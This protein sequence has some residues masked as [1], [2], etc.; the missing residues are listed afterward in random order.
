M[1]TFHIVGGDLKLDGL[2]FRYGQITVHGDQVR[3]DIR[4][5]DAPNN[6]S[7]QFEAFLEGE[8][9]GD[10]P[11]QKEAFEAL[12]EEADRQC[13]EALSAMRRDKYT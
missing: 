12:C 9:L 13:N 8:K 6:E 11:T 7:N 1:K 5:P 10:F 4:M 2:G 3:I